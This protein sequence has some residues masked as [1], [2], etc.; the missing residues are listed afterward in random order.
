MAKTVCVVSLNKFTAN[1][2]S[3]SAP[4]DLIMTVNKCSPASNRIKVSPA[5]PIFVGNAIEP[6]G[7]R[8]VPR[9]SLNGLDCVMPV[10]IPALI[11]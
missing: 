9:G 3:T 11:I 5:I 4:L 7:S 10:I 6:I 1:G 2:V 8:V